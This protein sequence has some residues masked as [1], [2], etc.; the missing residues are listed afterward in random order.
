[1]FLN[2]GVVTVG[3]KNG[4]LFR[5]KDTKSERSWNELVGYETKYPVYSL[6][7]TQGHGS[8]GPLL[9]GGGGDRYIT[10]WEANGSGAFHFVQRLGPH[11]GWVKDLAF[12][13]ATQRLYSIGCNCIETWDCEV[14]PATH[15]VKRAIGNSPDMGSTLSSDLLCLCLVPEQ[16]LVSG[17]VDGRIHLW[18]DDLKSTEPLFSE[19]CHDGRVNSLVYSKAM[20]VLFSVGNDSKV[21]AFRMCEE[22]FQLLGDFNVAGELRLSV[23]SIIRE[24]Y[25][26]CAMALGTSDGQVVLMNVSMSSESVD[27][28]ETSRV[29][30]IDDNPMIY[31]ICN[32]PKNVQS[33]TEKRILVGHAKGLVEIELPI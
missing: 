32:D 23:A 33:K 12:D 11:T 18:S 27:F 17:G 13:D 10:V 19:S 8:K 9:F 14:A 30:V 16:R 21:I 31:A 29:R 28:V 3:T 6:A 24:T 20:N 4:R 1:M 2:D 22:S 25:D 15:I 5:S 7:F 26:N